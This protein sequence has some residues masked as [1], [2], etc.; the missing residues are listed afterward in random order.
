MVEKWST[1]KNGK[2]SRPSNERMDLLSSVM[3]E[4][5]LERSNDYLVSEAYKGAE[6]RSCPQA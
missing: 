6:Y 4:I 5:R 2:R 3:R 1:R